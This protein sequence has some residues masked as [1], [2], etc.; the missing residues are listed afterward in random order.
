MNA[1]V[2]MVCPVAATISSYTPGTA[3]TY[4]TGKVM[5]HGWYPSE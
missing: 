4:G 5:G 3:P 2:G 1:N